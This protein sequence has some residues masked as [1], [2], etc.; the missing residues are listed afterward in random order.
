VLSF[1]Y[2]LASISIV[3]IDTSIVS[4]NSPIIGLLIVSK[5]LNFHDESTPLYIRT[6]EIF[7]YFIT[8][9]KS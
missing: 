2:L 3:F 7:L 8:Y 6:E 5:S 1:N 9:Y 4:H